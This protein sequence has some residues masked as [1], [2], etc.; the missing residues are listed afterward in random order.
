[1]R[2]STLLLSPPSCC[3]CCTCRGK[4]DADQGLKKKAVLLSGPPGI[5]KTSAALIVCR[6]LGYEP[7]EVGS[8]PC[9]ATP[10]FASS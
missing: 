1:M 4:R 2:S 6:E 7:V 9:R 3:A 8:R 10:L 5:G